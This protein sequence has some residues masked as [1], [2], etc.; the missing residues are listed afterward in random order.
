MKTESQGHA[1]NLPLKV[2]AVLA[3]AVEARKDLIKKGWSRSD[4]T[5]L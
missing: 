5:Y 1:L 2:K 4:R 3:V